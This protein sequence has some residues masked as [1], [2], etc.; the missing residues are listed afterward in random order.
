MTPSM[1]AAPESSRGA[2][3]V[4]T[5]RDKKPTSS[6]GALS[7]SV[8]VLLPFKPGTRICAAI[9]LESCALFLQRTRMSGMQPLGVA[10]VPA[11]SSAKP[12]SWCCTP[13]TTA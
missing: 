3:F 7:L 10:E 6:V 4:T 13:T 5:S 11:C 12:A 1:R 9:A 2:S 8:L